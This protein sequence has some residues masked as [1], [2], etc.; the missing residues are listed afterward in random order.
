M[1]R[2]ALTLMLGGAL[3]RVDTAGAESFMSQFKD[4]SDGWFDTS[5]W[6]L[7]NAAGF[8]PVPIVITEPA[9]GEGIG[10]AALFFHAPKDY[11]EEES[12]DAGLS[13]EGE[14][15]AFVRPNISVAA[16]AITTNGTW[17]VGGGHIA[18][19]RKDTIRYQGIAGYAEMKLT[20]YGEQGGIIDQIGGLDFV[21]KGVLIRQPLS[22]RLGK[23]N[24]FLGAQYDFSTMET[25]FA[26][27][28]EF[29]DPT[30]LNLDVTLSGLGAFLY[31]D[32]RDTQFTPNKGLEAKI[33]VRRN[34]DAI[35]SDR[36]FT[37]AEAYTHM[38]FTLSEKW[39]LGL[40]GD[41]EYVTDDAPFYALPFIDMRGIP[42]LR[43]QGQA[44]GV[45][46]AEARWAF[47]PRISLVGFLGAGRVAD[48]FSDLSDATTRTVRGLGLRYFLARKL[49]LHSGIDIANGPE[50]TEWYITVGGA[51]R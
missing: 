36:D 13:T 44:K 46:E 15:A 30:S 4:P 11:S 29:P 49:G 22:F 51:W 16:G 45:V 38:Y 40:R 8:L 3:L 43:Y 1:R 14:A 9:V 39:V 5:D 21:G 33:Q 17:F 48:S 25:R 47:H 50:G 41:V 2:I 26:P 35:G 27:D 42:A 23:S 12:E 32:N 19:W 28:A 7:N 24:F 18:Q 34:D 31:F 10:A 37:Y 6:V 20:F